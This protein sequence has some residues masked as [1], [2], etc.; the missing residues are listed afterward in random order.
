MAGE[1]TA[2]SGGA[3]SAAARDLDMVQFAIEC[4]LDAPDGWRPLVREMVARWPE[5]PVGELILALVTAATEIE[6]MFGPGSPAREG[7]ARGWRLA[8]LLGVDL[9]AMEAVGM[10]H[11]TA[12]DMARFWKIDPW[13]RDL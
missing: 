1:M 2:A 6:A 13:F 5:A 7:A 12:A 10:A 3:I 8:A 9:H 11:A 4:L